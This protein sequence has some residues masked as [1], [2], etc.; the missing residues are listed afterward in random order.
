MESIKILDQIDDKTNLSEAL[1]LVGEFKKA[2]ATEKEKKLW[3][4]PIG[5]PWL[6]GPILFLLLLTIIK[7]F[8]KGK[9]LPID[10]EAIK[11]T[12]GS[13]DLVDILLYGVWVILPPLVFL[14]EYVFLFGRNEQNRLDLSQITD[15]KYCHELASKIWAGVGV[16]LGIALLIKYGIKL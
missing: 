10:V 3:R 9:L 13:F 7:F 1:R 6:I 8:M 12:K 5:S 11:T 4:S 14:I 16:F 15:I 2:Y